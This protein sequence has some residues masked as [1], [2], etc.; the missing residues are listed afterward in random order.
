MFSKANQLKIYKL[1]EPEWE[2]IF[3]EQEGNK[4]FE[5]L[6]SI[7]DPQW[8]SES[9][10]I[11][12]EFSDIF[13]HYWRNPDYT[14]KYLFEEKLKIY[15]NEIIFKNFTQAILH[16]DNFGSADDLT[17]ISLE[18]DSI[19][20]RDKL[21]LVT[22]SISDLG[23]PIQEIQ[24]LS[25]ANNLPIGVKKNDIPFY[26][27]KKDNRQFPE[28]KYFIL[29]PRKTWNDFGVVSIFGLNYYD[30]G[31]ERSLGFLKIIYLEELVTWEHLPDRF[32]EL[33]EEF[34]SLSNEET[35]YLNLQIIFKESGM[36]SMLYALQD[37]A[38]FPDVHDRFEKNSGFIHSLLRSNNAERLLRTIRGALKG[39]DF[40]ESYSFSYRFQPPYSTSPLKVNFDFNDQQPLPNR[41]FA[42]I[43]KN[44]TGKTQL[45]TALPTSL[46]SGLEDDFYGK[47]PLFTR[48]IAVSYSVFDSY[49]I[50]Q[51]NATFNYVY[52]GL[53]D[54]KGEIRSHKGLLNSFHAHWKKIDE[55]RRTARWRSVLINFI[56]VEILDQFIL[57]SEET[58]RDYKVDI[59]GFHAIKSRLSSGQ[60]ILL[61]I[62]TQIVAN[63]RVDS[64]IIYDE[65]ETHLH[66]NAI[67]ELMNTIYEL[68]NEFE[69][70]CLVATHS[71]M[72]IRELFSKNVFV[73]ERNQNV[74]SVRRIGIEC[75]GENLGVLTDEV[76]GDREMPKQYKK[77]IQNLIS[78]G[79]SFSQIVNMLEY[80]K[81]PLSLNA[82]IYIASL[83]E[84]KR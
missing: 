49:S 26:V 6:R 32:F 4:A 8:T 65:P 22:V 18:I 2:R 52:C 14:T 74:P 51:K 17:D 34:C 27:V 31:F 62:I 81:F 37:A 3:N 84:G 38:M 83:I 29:T 40:S 55:M 66:P 76:F 56:D 28:E 78:S 67:V 60:S 63:I 72:V 13:Q 19:L 44:G 1:L 69:A 23:L 79:N 75:F 45:L 5:L 80:D 11:T 12:K 39:R 50:P 10:V 77:I 21:K 36:I 73:M 20:N 68:V 43:G 41:I 9:S 64:L 53:R 35:Y 59:K 46:S 16:P 24:E 71:P 70:Y 15:D 61:Y 33:T 7:W 57:K 42:I 25:D 58:S 47:I 82:R 30:D 48:I 54:E